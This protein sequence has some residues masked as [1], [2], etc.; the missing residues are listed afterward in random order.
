MDEMGRRSVVHSLNNLMTFPFIVEAVA[1]GTLALHG[2]W[3]EFETGR[4]LAYNPD[5]DSFEN[6]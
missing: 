1:A 2:A 3:H 5:T 6:A 4:L